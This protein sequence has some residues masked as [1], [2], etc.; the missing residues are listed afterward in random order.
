MAV[1]VSVLV[2]LAVLVAGD[3]FGIFAL[4]I[5]DFAVALKGVAVHIVLAMVPHYQMGFLIDD[6][7]LNK[8]QNRATTLQND[9]VGVFK[10]ISV[11]MHRIT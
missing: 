1:V 7:T 10:G 9:R 5:V 6:T 8:Q 3:C 4:S 11:F 2:V